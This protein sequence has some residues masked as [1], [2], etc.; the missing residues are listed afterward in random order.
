MY[1]QTYATFSAPFTAQ[2]TLKALAEE[3]RSY[4]P[5][6]AAFICTDIYVDDRL[7]DACSL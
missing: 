2:R 1:K 7:S 5:K 4:F 3:E 6:A